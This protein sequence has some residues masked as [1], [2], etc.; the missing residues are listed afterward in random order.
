M[1]QANGGNSR[2]GKVVRFFVTVLSVLM[3][4][5]GI[6]A[7]AE[8]GWIGL[9]G[10]VGGAMLLSSTIPVRQKA[11]AGQEESEDTCGEDSLCDQAAG[12]GEKEA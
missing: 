9:T 11:A 5:L 4:I 1:N 3:I 6:F 10:I 7:V 2:G 12:E 8:E